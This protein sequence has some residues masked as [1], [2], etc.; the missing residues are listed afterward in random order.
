M[1]LSSEREKDVIWCY[2][3]YMESMWWYMM[4][5]YDALELKEQRF[6]FR[7]K[8]SLLVYE[9]KMELGA[10]LAEPVALVGSHLQYPRF[11]KKVDG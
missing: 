4:S 9:M 3:K 11:L 2:I 6:D 1:I 5:A 8:Y 10:P 7:S